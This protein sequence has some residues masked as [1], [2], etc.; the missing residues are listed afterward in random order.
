[1]GLGDCSN[2]A[3]SSRG[4]NY[5]LILLDT[6]ADED[7]DRLRPLSY[8]GTDVFILC[9]SLGDRKTLVDVK[10]KWCRELLNSSS[11]APWLLVG[12]WSFEYRKNGGNEVPDVSSEQIGRA[13]AFLR[14]QCRG[15]VEY[16]VCDAQYDESLQ[17]IVDSVS[18]LSAARNGAL[19]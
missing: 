7:H 10:T 5:S 11:A 12:L 2:A 14:G 9:F 18:S 8:P 19:S 16:M 15:R 13:L 4:T 3:G 1:M 17:P 6:V